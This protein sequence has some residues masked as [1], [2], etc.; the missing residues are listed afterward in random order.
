M[1]LKL[2]DPRPV[3]VEARELPQ[4]TGRFCGRS[5]EMKRGSWNQEPFF[6]V[7]SNYV[8]WVILILPPFKVK[9]ANIMLVSI[10]CHIFYFKSIIFRYEMRT[11]LEENFQ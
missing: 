1:K 2:T 8:K 9:N 3:Q 7:A 4:P 5:K 6:K 11:Y 10:A